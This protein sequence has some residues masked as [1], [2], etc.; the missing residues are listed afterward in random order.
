LCA[1]ANQVQEG[2]FCCFC[3]VLRTPLKASWQNP[4]PIMSADIHESSK[5]KKSIAEA[6]PDET[7]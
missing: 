2:W 6:V 4:P 5:N 7:R 3:Q 1:V